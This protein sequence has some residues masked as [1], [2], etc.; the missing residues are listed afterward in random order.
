M[1]SDHASRNSTVSS[2]PCGDQTVDEVL[3]GIWRWRTGS[4][5]RISP[6]RVRQSLPLTASLVNLPGCNFPFDSTLLSARGSDRSWTLTLPHS[7]DEGIFGFGLQLK[8]H[9]QSGKKRSLRVNADPVLDQGDSHAPVPFYVSTR[10]YAVLVDTARY[11]SVYVGTHASVS[12][13]RERVYEKGNEIKFSVDDL[14][15]STAIGDRVVADIPAA[16]GADVYIFGGPDALTALRR[17]VLFSGG[18]C[19][20]PLWSLGNWYRPFTNH[21]SEDVLQLIDQFQADG[22]PFEVIGLE[23]GWQSRFYP[24]SFT[25]SSRFPD[26]SGFANTLHE[27][28]M[29]L[30]LWENAFIHPDSPMADSIAPH[31]ASELSTD[32]LVP[33]F[34]EPEA[35]GIF[36]DYHARELVDQGVDGFK[37]DECDNGDFL[38]FAWS[39]PEFSEFPSGADGEQMHVLYGTLYQRVIDRVFASRNRRHYGLVRSSGALASPLP[40][41]LYSDLYDA[42]DFRRGLV[43]AGTSGLLWSPEVRHA[44]SVED[45]VRRVQLTVLSPLSLIN[46]WYIPRPPWWQIDTE[47]NKIGIPMDDQENIKI[48]V[49]KALTLR[50]QLIPYLYSAFASYATEGTPPFRAMFLECPGDPTAWKCDDQ[51]MIGDSLLAAPMIAGESDRSVFL[52]PGIWYNFAS[53]QRLQGGQCI[54]LSNVSLETIPL[55]VRDGSLIPLRAD[56]D[57]GIAS[58]LPMKITVRAYGPGPARGRLFLDDG[59]SYAYLDPTGGRDIILT[60]GTDDTLHVDSA[61]CSTL[62]H[63]PDFVNRISDGSTL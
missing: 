26:P 28:G 10:G 34:L 61:K 54:H 14:Y 56:C 43:N 22:M 12:H 13:I 42:A 52:P 58:G 50:M 11:A 21:S 49:R 3:P 36:A 41:A 53:G 38:P 59:I 16:Q 60:C 15:Q 62:Y 18:G 44:T 9:L 48:L 27:K 20:P 6:V 35:V 4:P 25:W 55:F 46:A 47:M 8:S 33:D 19:F 57:Q 40:F 29:F 31:C 32:G 5:E 45:L 63:L 2:N 30:N 23:P 24:N 1:Q 51:F 39:F 37:L 7:R 17:Y